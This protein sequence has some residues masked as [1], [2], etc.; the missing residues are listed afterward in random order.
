LEEKKKKTLEKL[1]Q[2]SHFFDLRDN[3]AEIE[4]TETAKDISIT[5]KGHRKKKRE[6]RGK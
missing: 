5:E 2:P 4:H 3:T 6:E 1:P